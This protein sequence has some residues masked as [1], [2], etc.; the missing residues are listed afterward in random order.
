M[1][2]NI[3]SHVNS[4]ST[5]FSAQTSVRSRKELKLHSADIAYLKILRH[6]H[7]DGSGKTFLTAPT[8]PI[9][10]VKF[11]G[12]AIHYTKQ[13]ERWA[14]MKAMGFVRY[15]RM[16]GN[17]RARYIHY[18]TDKGLSAV[19]NYG[20]NFTSLKK[21][22]TSNYKKTVPR[23]EKN[24]TSL[25]HEVIE[26]NNHE[27]GPLTGV[28]KK[29]PLPNKLAGI[30]IETLLALKV[31]KSLAKR[32]FRDHGERKVCLAYE[33]AKRLCANNI[34]AYM[35]RLLTK[36][37]YSQREIAEEDQFYKEMKIKDR[38]Q[39]N[40][41]FNKVLQMVEEE[42]LSKDPGRA[43]QAQESLLNMRKLLDNVKTKS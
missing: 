38:N 9:Y 13:K 6:F 30:N 12:K 3:Q 42:T 35:N 21:N 20:R 2:S 15:E 23:N 29:E 40:E 33:E 5:N 37:F 31:N 41:G 16:N 39:T 4:L 8:W 7:G 36:G 18:L 17:Q 19:N 43:S 24:G 25:N 27:H 28:D 11:G 26:D 14:K 32:W 22:G 34:G 1:I 10:L